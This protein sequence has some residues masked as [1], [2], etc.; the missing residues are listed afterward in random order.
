MKDEEKDTGRIEAFSDGV[1]SIAIT[2]LA[3]ELKIPY[4]VEGGAEGLFLA[5]TNQ[6]PSYLSFV[7]SFCTILIM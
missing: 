6:W 3:L 7:T 4:S 2:L 5:L 1:F